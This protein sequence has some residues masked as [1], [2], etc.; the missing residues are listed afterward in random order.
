MSITD[1][2]RR[3]LVDLSDGSWSRDFQ[4]TYASQPLNALLRAG[5]IRSD[6]HCG[7]LAGRNWT[8]TQDGLDALAADQ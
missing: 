2:Q 8:A 7:A 6:V 4:R 1:T 3:I 5:F